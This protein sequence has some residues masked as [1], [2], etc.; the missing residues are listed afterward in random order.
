MTGNYCLLPWLFVLNAI[1]LTPIHHASVC[2][3]ISLPQGTADPEPDVDIE[4][5]DGDG[6]DADA[7]VPAVST[8][9]SVMTATDQV[10]ET[11]S[12]FAC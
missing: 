2:Y 1:A 9:D 12:C 5:V 8:V 6:A 10:S 4:A 11:Q 3:P 7:G